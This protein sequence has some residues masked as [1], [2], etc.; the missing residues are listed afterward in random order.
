MILSMSTIIMVQP[1]TPERIKAIAH[2]QGGQ[3]KPIPKLIKMI[4]TLMIFL[5]KL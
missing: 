5:V 2:V 4:Q 3:K 1:T